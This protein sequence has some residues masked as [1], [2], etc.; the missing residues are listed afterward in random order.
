MGKSSLLKKIDVWDR[1]AAR[2]ILSRTLFGFKR[3][4]IDL[5][6]SYSLDEFVDDI[7]LAELPTP[8]PPGDWVNEVPSPD[9]EPAVY[10]QRMKELAFWQIDLMRKNEINFRERMVLFWSNNFTSEAVKVRV[11]QYMYMQNYLF[12]KQAFGNL[13]EFTKEITI[14][15]AM[16][17]YLDGVKNRKNNPNENYA[18]ELL[19]LFT[20]GIGNYEE[21]DI[22]DGAKALTGWKVI[23]LQSVFIRRLFNNDWKKFLGWEGYFNYED[24]IDI[25]YTKKETAESFCR[26]F[27]DEFVYYK[28]NEDYVK[29][30]SDVMMSNNYDVKPVLSAMLKSEFFHSKDIRAAKI[31]SPIELLIGSVKK[32]NIDDAS[33]K[34]IKRSSTLLQQILFNPPDVRGWTGQRDWISTTTLPLRNSISEAMVTGEVFNGIHLA[35]KMNVLDFSR[36]F[37]SSEDAEKFVN[38]VAEFLFEFPL[39]EEKKKEMLNVLLDG[40]DISE[41]STYDPEAESRLRNFFT[42]LLRLPEYQLS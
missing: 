16:L 18:R 29:E 37:D 35:F 3:E 15:P 40:S 34:F 7:L 24:I 32:L 41:W 8:E 11:P 25:I 30:L 6:L 36:S 13:I 19:E 9:D 14:D 17:I 4:D 26:K 33:D 38:D 28:P 31:K 5:A 42:T 22:H 1:D 23:G 12:R 2:H 20:I 21:P 39:S 10:N 27:Y